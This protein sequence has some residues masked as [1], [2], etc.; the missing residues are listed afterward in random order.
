M[1]IKSWKSREVNEIIFV[2]Y[3]AELADPEW[4]LEPVKQITDGSWRFQGRNEFYINCHI[5]VI[6]IIHFFRIK[7]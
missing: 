7:Y 1:E 6:I 3:H 5:Q 2:W 4:E